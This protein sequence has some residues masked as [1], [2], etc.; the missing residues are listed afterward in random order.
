EQIGGLCIL[1]GCMPSK[2]LIESANRFLT[3]RHAGEVGL[4]AGEISFDGTAIIARKKRLIAEFA[5]YR[6]EQLE[7]GNFEF[8]RG[9]ATFSD[10]HSLTVQLRGGGTRVVT[11][12]SFLIATGSTL[13]SPPIPGL[14]EADCLTSDDVLDLEKIPQAIIVL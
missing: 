1:R 2:T 13:S 11:A 10:P 14:D 9:H 5:N 12:Q 8:V 3:L 7:T 6:R 4:Q